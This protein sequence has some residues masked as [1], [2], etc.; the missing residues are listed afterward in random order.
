MKIHKIISL[1]TLLI[2]GIQLSDAQQL[3]VFS[4]YFLNPFFYNPARAGTDP[5]GGRI[6]LAFQKQWDRVPSSPITT[7][8]SWDGRIKSSNMALGATIYHDRTTASWQNTV[9]S[10]A[11]A[12]HIPFNKE[13]SHFLSIGLQA[14]VSSLHLHDFTPDQPMDPV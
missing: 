7:Y 12:Y 13:K 11:Y 3:P 6:N 9:G 8:G 5:D 2:A 4:N 10:L 1:V 14:G